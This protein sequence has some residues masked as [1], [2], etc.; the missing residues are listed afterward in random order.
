MLGKVWQWLL[1][2]DHRGIL[3]MAGGALVAIAGGAWAVF[4]YFRPKRVRHANPAVMDASRTSTIHSG[5]GGAVGQ[6][7][8]G[9]TVTISTGPTPE[10]IRALR[11]YLKTLQRLYQSRA[12][13]SCSKPR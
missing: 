6:D 3:A 5:D 8:H 1:N 13:A 4:V 2:E 9:G 7:V 10:H 12:Q 11:N